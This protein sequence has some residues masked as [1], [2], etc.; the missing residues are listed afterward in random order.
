FEQKGQ[1]T[2]KHRAEKLTARRVVYNTFSPS[3][4]QCRSGLTERHYRRYGGF[5]L[6]EQGWLV[7]ATF[8]REGLGVV[9]IYPVV[10]RR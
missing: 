5:L 7:D 9:C 8:D 3:K 6:V 1:V 2:G 10:F 4:Q